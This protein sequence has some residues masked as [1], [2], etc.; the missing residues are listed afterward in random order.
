MQLFLTLLLVADGLFDFVNNKKLT[1]LWTRAD[2][3]TVF[4]YAAA[5]ASNSLFLF[6]QK[7]ELNLVLIWVLSNLI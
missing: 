4:F 1:L 7:N 6:F 3:S 5:I 2:L